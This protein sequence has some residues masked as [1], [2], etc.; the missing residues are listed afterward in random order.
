MYPDEYEKFLSK[1]AVINVKIGSILSNSCIISTDFY[2][3]LLLATI[4][5]AV[6]L[7]LLFGTLWIASRRNRA[8]ETGATQHILHNKRAST[9]LFVLFFVYSTV[10]F[11]I[12]QTFVCDDLDDG[13][14]YLRADYS[15]ECNTAKHDAYVAYASV[16]VCVY[17][18]GIPAF[19]G[20]WL[21]RN[22]HD[23]AKPGREGLD[24]LK[25]CRGLWVAYNPSC[26]YYE[27]VEC[28]RRIALTGAA[29]FVLPD[30]VEQIAVIFLLS[31]V[32]T[33]IFESLA[34]FQSKAD[35][36]MYRWGNA[37]ILASMYVALVLKAQ[38][39]DA[40][41]E[42]SSFMTVVLIAANVLLIATVVVQT[43]LLVRGL[44]APEPVVEQITPVSSFFRNASL[45]EIEAS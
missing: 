41:S 21:A 34:P 22:R 35:M 8:D 18:V 11:T 26:Y 7:L 6:V 32:F 37:I 44:Y 10:S 5:P 9:G 36:W 40:G 42:T 45:Q 31:V 24:H 2:D 13:M 15:I 23:L 19:F 33:F 4:T 16:M 3:S 43:A 1:L 39:T 27:V 29:V 17:P 12:F 20:W 38:L 30:S 28:C 14:S 25:S